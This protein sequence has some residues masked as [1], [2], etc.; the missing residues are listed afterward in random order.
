MKNY[1]QQKNVLIWIAGLGLLCTLFF[2]FPQLDIQI[3]KMF[4]LKGLGFTYANHL[5][6]KTM[7]VLVPWLTY[8]AAII[9]ISLALYQY[10]IRKKLSKILLYLIITLIIGPGLI[11]NSILKEHFGRARPKSVIEFGGASTFS[12]LLVFSDQCSTN[13]SFSSGHAAAGYYFTSFSFIAPRR[14]FRRLF[15]SGVLFGSAIG[16]VRIIQG[17]HFSSDVLFSFLVV[18]IVNYGTK[19]LFFKQRRRRVAI[20]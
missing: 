3:S 5:L 16:L 7:F 12:S 19:I 18:L 6:A 20:Y 15:Y 14:Y 11:V 1:Y 17:G 4:Y 9:Y 13:C 8:T 10:F 2:L